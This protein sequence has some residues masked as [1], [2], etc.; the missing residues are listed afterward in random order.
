VSVRISSYDRSEL[1]AYLILIVA[2]LIYFVTSPMHEDFSWGDTANQAM[3]G[4]L[5][6]DYLKS[7]SPLSPIRFAGEYYLHYPALNIALY[8]PL[9]PIAEAVTYCVIGFSHVT[10]QLTVTAFTLI[11]VCFLY[12]SLRTAYASMTAAGAVLILLSMPCV[13]LWSRQVMMEMPSLAML[14]CASFYLL[15]YMECRRPL[16]LYLSIV[17]LCGAIYVKQTAAFAI[18]SFGLALLLELGLPVF[19][20]RATWVA[21][22]LG[23]VLLTPLAAMFV[24]VGNHYQE[25]VSGMGDEAG[26]NFTWA[27]WTWYVRCLPS[28]AGWGPLAGAVIGLGLLMARGFLNPQER[29]LVMLML[30]W[31][32]TDYIFISPIAHREERYAFLLLPPRAVLATVALTRVVP[33]LMKRGAVMAFGVVAFCFTVAT[34]PVPRVWGYPAVADYL[35][36]AAPPNSTII[37][38]GYRSSNFVFS[39]RSLSPT[40]RNFIVRA[41][42]FLAS[43][44][45]IREWGIKDRGLSVEQIG[46]LFDQW[47]VT[48]VAAQPAFWSDLPS[49]TALYELLATDQFTKVAEFPITGA[50][51]LG[52]DKIVVY[53]NNQPGRI[54]GHGFDVDIP[55]MNLTIPSTDPR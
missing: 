42:K 7:L 19:R 25:F 55:I 49:V 33:R 22:A 21:M 27:S 8:P 12:R 46:Q 43:Y 36:Q 39:M 44:K 10:A 31:F 32:L 48:Y 34:N 16:Q 45:I 53:R 5:I 14:A 35:R 6:V 50:R 24:F 17:L 37:F 54:P 11:G 29:R 40:P 41:D 4:I 23:L 1:A 18:I 2:V 51:H 26:S 9:F 38:H 3:N 15:R 47:G 52:E 30:M 13:A 20:T 28:V